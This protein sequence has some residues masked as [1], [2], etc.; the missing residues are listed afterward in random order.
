MRAFGGPIRL[1]GDVHVLRRI[2]QLLDE[3][4]EVWQH[5]G[6]LDRIVV[7][8]WADLLGG[9][10]PVSVES[11]KRQAEQMRT[12]LEG[13]NPSALEKLLVA[14]VIAHWLEV[15][16]AQL[17]QSDPGRAPADQNAHQLKRLESA[18]K[19]YLTAL[20]ALTTARALLPRGLDP[21]T[22]LRLY[23]PDDQLASA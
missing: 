18:Q 12:E 6:D 16:H 9:N 13:D 20:K 21:G 22:P 23:D 10:N 4:P 11:I 14:N 15:S 19:R 3:H 17:S 7:R 8:S 2:R 5:A 1:S